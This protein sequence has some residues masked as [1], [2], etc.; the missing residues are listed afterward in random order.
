[1]WAVGGDVH[2]SAD[3]RRDDSSRHARARRRTVKTMVRSTNDLRGA[4][5]ARARGG[6]R[7]RRAGSRPRVR[8]ARV[9]P[10]LHVARHAR[11]RRASTA[12]AAPP[13]RRAST[14]SQDLSSSPTAPPWFTRLQQL[15]GPPRAARRHGR[16]RGRLDRSDLPRR[17]S[18][19]RHHRRGRARAR[20]G[21]STIRRT[22]LARARRHDRAGRVAQP[23]DPHDR[24]DDR[25]RAGGVRRRRRLRRRRRPAPRARSSSSSST[26]RTTRR[27][28]S[29]SSTSRT[30]ASG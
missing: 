22:S 11:A 26:P 9:G 12:T 20:T 29:T 2:A 3:Q 23:Q 14:R 5:A 19:R 1:M 10:R 27:A 25:L 28:T 15:P 16:E 18:A 4:L 17:R 21:S 13:A 7:S 6:L 30:S 8:R 24:S